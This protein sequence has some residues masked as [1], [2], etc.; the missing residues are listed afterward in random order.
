[1]VSSMNFQNFSV[2]G[3]TEPPPQTPPRSMS[4]VAFDFSG[5]CVLG[6]GCALNSPLQH[7]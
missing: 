4:G 1:M 6:S 2:E 5:A 3:L 7:V